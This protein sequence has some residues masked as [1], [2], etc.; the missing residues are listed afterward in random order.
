[1]FFLSFFPCVV[2]S[3]RITS[4]APDC[5][6][7]SRN[8]PNSACCYYKNG[9]LRGGSTVVISLSSAFRNFTVNHD[10]RCVICQLKAVYIK[11]MSLRRLA[12]RRFLPFLCLLREIQRLLGRLLK[13]LS[14]RNFR[15]TSVSM[16]SCTGDRIIC[17]SEVLQR[18]ACPSHP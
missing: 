16:F 10:W 6:L 5:F 8:I 3:A 12:I 17:L 2:H 4:A 15:P 13:C 9:Q 18:L 11:V 7:T 1:M 14:G